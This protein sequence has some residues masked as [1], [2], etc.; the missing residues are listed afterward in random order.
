MQNLKVQSNGG[1]SRF[2]LVR[3]PGSV[4]GDYSGMGLNFLA[5]PGLVAGSAG[6]IG[7]QVE[8]LRKICAQ[9]YEL[10]AGAPEV[11]QEHAPDLNPYYFDRHSIFFGYHP[12]CCSG[13]QKKEVII[14][15][16]RCRS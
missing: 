11:V 16:Q 7:G 12:N 1:P 14:W 2:L 10:K 15:T 5:D 9:Q 3:I 4:V 13:L 6:A 8:L